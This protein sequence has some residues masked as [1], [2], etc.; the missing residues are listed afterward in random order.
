MADQQQML[1]YMRA[2]IEHYHM[3]Q[4]N[5]RVAVGVSGG[6]DSVALLA[7]L[8]MY[9][10]FSPVP[11]TLTAITLDP[12]FGGEETDFSPVAALCE[13]LD[14]PYVLRR[15]RLA[16]AA[17]GQMAGK[18][19]CSLCAKMRRGALH[20]EAQE[21][22]CHVVALGH[23]KDDA[24]ETV[25][26]NLLEGGRFACFSPVTELSRR[27]LRLIRPLLFCEERQIASYARREGLPVVASRCPV[28]GHTNRQKTKD[29][30][31]TL[32]VDYGDVTEK[33][34]HAL[35]TEHINGW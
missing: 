15:T 27:D 23:H 13:R 32:S 12:G 2:A 21:A 10:R 25:L 18:V 17:M 11:F 19:P 34:V 20:R 14:V 9:R 22:G 7:L 29:L 26:M 30:V 28:D 33:I 5:D 1:A 31:R 35:Q 24:A 4:A 16:D 3:I 6:K 8:S